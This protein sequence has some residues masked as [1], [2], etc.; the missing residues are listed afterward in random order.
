MAK[1]EKQK[2][3]GAKQSE[4]LIRELTDLLPDIREEGL[5][6]L[7]DQARVLLHNQQVEKVNRELE[8]LQEL[9]RGRRG[10]ASPRPASAAGGVDIEE[11]GS[12]SNFILVLSPARKFLNREEMRGLVRLCRAPDSAGEA[13]PRLYRWLG[14]NRKDILLDAGLKSGKDPRLAALVDLVRRRYTLASER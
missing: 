2:K 11:D 12:G 9:E 5:R 6:F 13:G 7:L 1:Q 3:S 14:E 10:S 4:G 8:K